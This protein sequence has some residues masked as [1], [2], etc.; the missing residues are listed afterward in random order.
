MLRAS[1]RFI[2]VLLSVS[3]LP[4]AGRPWPQSSNE[5]RVD[6][7]DTSLTRILQYGLW[8]AEPGA[9]RT[10]VQLM[11]DPSTRLLQRKTI[12]IW[13]PMPSRRRHFAW[14]PANGAGLDKE[15]ASGEGQLIWRTRER[16]IYDLRS[17]VAT[18]QG[19]MA[20]GRPSGFGTFNDQIGEV[21]AG[22]WV[23]GDLQGSGHLKLPNGDDYEGDFLA[24]RPHGK[25]R[26]I[27]A[28]GEI[29]QGSFVEGR[30][31]GR[32]TTILSSGVSYQSYWHY[33]VEIL[34]SRRVRLA[35]TR[36]PLTGSPTDE[37]V[38]IG[39]IVNP[40]AGSSSRTWATTW[41]RMSPTELWVM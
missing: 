23:D 17:V 20:N 38:R 31:E 11:I 14:V 12:T 25:G 41:A 10:K 22:N 24:G 32:A 2:A 28:A 26:Y 16:P 13:D 9:W 7:V 36:P 29:Y 39:V 6:D 18:Y 19:G 21:Y 5:L 27:D 35:Q 33:G 37:D 40:V 4:D 3:L 15:I 30:R 34:E 1:L 8:D